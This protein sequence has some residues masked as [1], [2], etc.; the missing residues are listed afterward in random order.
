MFTAKFFSTVLIS[1]FLKFSLIDACDDPLEFAIVGD[2][3]WS[4]KSA[5]EHDGPIK[6]R[7]LQKYVAS[8]I[9]NKKQWKGKK[10]PDFILNVGDSF[11]Y[12]GV[13]DDKDHQ[14]KKTWY[15]VYSIYG[16]TNKPWVNALGN[17]DLGIASNCVCI[18]P[19]NTP[20]TE[21]CP[22]VNPN[23]SYLGR[24]KK[25]ANWVMKGRN[26]VYGD[27]VDSYSTNIIVL[28]TNYI[29]TSTICKISGG[30]CGNNT[31]IC[32][33]KLN[34]MKPLTET[35]LFEEL[36]KNTANTVIINQHYPSF[37]PGLENITSMITSYAETN[38]N[39]TILFAGG[40]VHSTMQTFNVSSGAIWPSN[41][42]SYMAGGGGGFNCIDSAEQGF[43]NVKIDTNG[44]II[45]DEA[46]CRRIVH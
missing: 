15:D 33:E 37:Y 8:M 7:T 35:F 43:I 21:Q 13:K 41:V 34:G 26:Y 16:L 44:K 40:H 22:E 38:P 24:G 36:E 6:T 9:G 46:V 2:F 10:G 32:T 11:Y 28:D 5:I 19:T 27:Y 39:K 4:L 31:N 25:K 29:L 12:D 23:L 20:T 14:W 18:N 1:A 45:Q 30:S 3:G 17:H 42:I